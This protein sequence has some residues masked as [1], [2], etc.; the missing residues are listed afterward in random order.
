M[1][2]LLK[3]VTDTIHTLFFQGSL[4]PENTYLDYLQWGL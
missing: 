3:H 4:N 1:Y 2:K